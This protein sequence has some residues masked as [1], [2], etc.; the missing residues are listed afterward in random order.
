MIARRS[1]SALLGFSSSSS[2]SASSAPSSSRLFATTAPVAQAPRPPRLVPKSHHLAKTPT[3]DSVYSQV[4]S[5]PTHPLLGFFAFD[6]RKITRRN[7]EGVEED[8]EVSVPVALS[9]RD[10]GKDGV[11]SRAWLAPELRK[12]SSVELHQL[13]YA[14]LKERNRLTS[15][16]DELRRSGARELARYANLNISFIDR[17]VSGISESADAGGR[18]CL[19]DC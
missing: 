16:R 6:S 1:G 2:S 3:P 13:W 11:S 5:Y 19:K 7:A 10:L 18:L 17:R 4:Q 15:T 12:K 9:E 14:C 8:V